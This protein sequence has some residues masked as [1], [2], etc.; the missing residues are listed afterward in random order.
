MLFPAVGTIPPASLCL[1]PTGALARAA[2]LR[3]GTSPGPLLHGPAGMAPRGM[4]GLGPVT[5]HGASVSTT[6]RLG[7]EEGVPGGY[8]P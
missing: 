1:P 4:L 8:S 6:T 3:V 2:D 5:S 7:R